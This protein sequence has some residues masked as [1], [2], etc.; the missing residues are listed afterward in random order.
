MRDDTGAAIAYYGQA[1]LAGGPCGDELSVYANPSHEL[2]QQLVQK[3]SGPGNCCERIEA[4]EVY[5]AFAFSVLMEDAISNRDHDYKVRDRMSAGVIPMYSLT[6]ARR[7]MSD[8]S[9]IL[10]DGV[11]ADSLYF[12]CGEALRNRG[13]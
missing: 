3:W 1:H 2:A 12:S 4:R 6:Q 5:Q 10:T 9:C 13:R 7:A 8:L 11:Q